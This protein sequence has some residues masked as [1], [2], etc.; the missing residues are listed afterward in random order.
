M[1]SWV[2]IVQ[3]V[4]QPNNNSK[5]QNKTS[6]SENINFWDDFTEASENTWKNNVKQT[7]RKIQET[8]KQ[9]KE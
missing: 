4:Q 5:I 6:N 7:N 3:N 9:R 8:I 2:N 1:N